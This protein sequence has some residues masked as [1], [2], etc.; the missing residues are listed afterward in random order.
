MFYNSP[1]NP[2]PFRNAFVTQ[3]DYVTFKRAFGTNAR[4]LKHTIA[5][6]VW[7]EGNLLYHQ[8]LIVPTLL[9]YGSNDQF[10]ELQEMLDMQRV[11]YFDSCI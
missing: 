8:C 2:N 11:C 6:Q 5:G 1:A 3:P 10:V 9:I 7:N 4:T